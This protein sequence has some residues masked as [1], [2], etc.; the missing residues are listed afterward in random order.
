MMRACIR[1]C[2]AVAA[3]GIASRRR[4]GGH[5]GVLQVHMRRH[6]RNHYKARQL[7]GKLALVDLAGSE[8][9][10][11][12]NNMGQKL[13]DGANINRSLLSLANCIHQLGKGGA[14]GAGGGRTY[15]PYRNSKLTR[16]LKD[17]LEGNSRT[18]MVATV[19]AA[20]DQY[21]HS[22]NT[23]KY[24]NRAKD[25]K[26]HIVQNVASVE[27]HVADYRRIIDN[28]QVRPT[29]SRDC[30]LTHST[31]GPSAQAAHNPSWRTTSPAAG[32]TNSR[33][34]GAEHMAD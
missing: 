25:I 20:S 3:R 19:A 14:A 33:V 10:A 2:C 13:R 4:W 18:V 8:R 27:S 22:I 31:V 21:H 32:L 5:G 16:L 15:V 6:R 29:A 17:G 24:A 9:A 28:L 11:E 34:V 12:T 26:T 23:L 30:H 1:D 7:L